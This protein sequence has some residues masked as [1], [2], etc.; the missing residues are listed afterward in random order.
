MQT[1]FKSFALSLASLLIIL[2]LGVSVSTQAQDEVAAEAGLEKLDEAMQKKL[3]AVRLKDLEEVVKACADAIEAGLSAENEAFATQMM[4]STLYERA[5]RLVEPILE[6]NVD[7]TWKRRRD[8]AIESLRK[9]IK[10]DDQN[11]DA[12][13]LLAKLCRLPYGD[14]KAGRAAANKAVTLFDEVP[15]RRAEALVVVSQFAESPEEQIEIL[16][17]A[18]AADAANFDA[19]RDRGDAKLISG[20]HEGAIED[21]KKI[22]EDDEDN[23]AALQQ[24]VRAFAAIEDFD[25]AMKSVNRVI[26]LEHESPTGFAMRSSL[27]LMQDKREDAVDDL[28]TA[29]ELAPSDIRILMTR[30]GL[31]ELNEDFEEAFADI[32]RVLEIRPGLPDALMMRAEIAI[33]AEQ[34]EEAILAYKELV[35]RDPNN[36]A[37]QMQLAVIYSADA[38]PR[39]AVEAYSQM[40]ENEDTELRWQALRGRGDVRLAIGAH[41]EAIAD[42]EQAMKLNPEDDGILNNLA[43][44]LATST[45]DEV[46]DGKRAIKFAKQA[47]ELTDY[48]APHIL[49]TLAA[50]YAET[51]DFETAREWSQKAVDLVEEEELKGQLAEEFESYKA[52][53]PWRELQEEEENS[54]PEP[55]LG[56]SDDLLLDAEAEPAEMDDEISEQEVGSVD[57]EG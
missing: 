34:F 24:I 25:E 2:V 52:E 7:Q 37:Y 23:L 42:Y 21:F 14:V 54:E 40:L 32:D 17:K 45:K 36:E 18:I 57:A 13:L 55:E 4:T 41:A 38:R 26:E 16:D 3:G 8:M 50:G 43:W 48:E 1:A 56:L 47:C 35:E 28:D 11:A 15:A 27:Y 10:L 53:K 20:D 39:R 44:V 9:A 29:V 51:G 5:E 22:L 12:L 33:S 6:G 31:L 49:S 46:R 19:W 30:A